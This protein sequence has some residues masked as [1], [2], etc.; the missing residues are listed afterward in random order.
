ME[1]EKQKPKFVQDARM[2]WYFEHKAELERDHPG[3]WVAIGPNGIVAWGHDL[4]EMKKKARESGVDDPLFAPIRD[5][6]LQGMKFI[7]RSVC[8]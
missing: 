6:E 4:T 5:R 7:L 8:R 3:E 1:E 2:Q